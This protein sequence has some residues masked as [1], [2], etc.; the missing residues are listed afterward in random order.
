MLGLFERVHD[1]PEE[2]LER[3]QALLL[4]YF[5]ASAVPTQIYDARDGRHLGSNRASLNMHGLGDTLHPELADYNV[6]EDPMVPGTHSDPIFPD[7]A[8]GGERHTARAVYNVRAPIESLARTR[9]GSV[10]A[11]VPRWR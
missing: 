4:S 3:I 5:D 6:L 9:A 11:V 2:E 7:P 10:T 1:D 8:A